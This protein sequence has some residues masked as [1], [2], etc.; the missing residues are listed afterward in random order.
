M[1]RHKTTILVLLVVVLI[2]VGLFYSYQQAQTALGQSMGTIASEISRTLNSTVTIEDIKV[3]SFN[4]LTLANVTV[5]DRKNQKIFQI[6]LLDVSFNPL[7]LL[8]KRT[9]VS[10]IRK[11]VLY[12]PDI[13]IRQN[14]DGR[15]NYEDFLP[16]GTDQDVKLR[17]TAIVKD[18]TTVVDSQQGQWQLSNLNGEIDFSNSPTVEFDVSAEHNDTKLKVKGNGVKERLS[19]R[20]YA[21]QAEIAHYRPLLPADIL[22]VNPEGR[23]HNLF[24]ALNRNSKGE[25]SYA[26]EV[27]IDRAAA[28]VRDIAITDA[29]GFFA[30]NNKE[31]FLYQG[32]VK[33]AGQ[34]VAVSGKVNIN[35]P[36]PQLKLRVASKKFDPAEF[37]PGT[38]VQGKLAFSADVAGTIDNPQVT[39]TVRM[40][41]GNITGYAVHNVVAAVHY[42]DNSLY[43]DQAGM[44]ILGGHVSA[45]G[46]IE[47][48]QPSYRLA[49]EG[50]NLEIGQIPELAGELSGRAN[51]N[52]IV[53]GADISTPSI[54]GTV[55]MS[56]GIW[57]QLS[58]SNFSAGFNKNGENI[59]FDYINFA[60][61]TGKVAVNG[62][63]T[64]QNLLLTGFGNK[65]PLKALQ[66]LF[67]EAELSGTADATARISGTLRQPL[68][69]INFDAEQ[70]QILKQ[71][72][73]IAK[74]KVTLT[75]TQA[76][77]EEIKLENRATRHVVKGSIGLTA[78]KPLDLFIYT[79]QARAEN[80]SE[81]LL[82]GE[83]ITGNVD[84]EMHITGTIANIQAQGRMKLTEG[85]FRGYLV[86]QGDGQYTRQNGIVE[87]KDF[88]IT[89]LNTNL[90]F[91]GIIQPNNQLNL[92]V[93]A[94]DIDLSRVYLDL[95][96]AVTGQADFSGKLI[97]SPQYPVFNGRFT[98]KEIAANGQH[99]TDISGQVGIT[100]KQIDIS[101]FE[102]TQQQGKYSFAGGMH[103]ETHELDGRFEVKNGELACLLGLLN[104]PM[105]QIEGKLNGE[106]IIN[107]K[108][109]K[110]NVWVNGR[111]LAGKI[112]NFPL[113]KIDFDI[114][115][116]NDVMTVNNFHAQQG[117]G[118]VIMK[119][120]A[121]LNGSLDV[122]IGAKDIDAGLL[123]AWLDSTVG[124]NGKLNMV[125]QVSGTA[126]APHAAVS[127]Q[128]NKGQVANADFDDLYGMF[129]IQNKA[130][131]VNQFFIAKGDYRAS[132]YGLIPLNALNPK[133]RQQASA[134]DQMDLKIKLDHADLSILPF[135]TK[136]VAWAAGPTQ[137][138]LTVGGTLMQP[139]LYGRLEVNNGTVKF[140][141]INSP[142]Q[143]VGVDIQFEGDKINVQAFKGQIGAGSYNLAGSAALNGLSVEDYNLS[144]SMDKLGIDSKYFK[145]PLSGQLQFTG[146]TDKPLL[147]GQV[148][149]EKNTIIIPTMPQLQKS[150]LDVALDLH[151]HIGNR[152]RVYNPLLYDLW[153]EPGQVSFAGSTQEPDV[154]GTI[155]A[156]RG[157][158]S[159]LRTQFKIQA[160]S[161]AFTQ[162]NSFEPVISLQAQTRLVSTLVNLDVKGPLSQM[163]VRLSSEPAMS[164]QAILSL[165]TLRSRY[166]DKQKNS[167]QV[168]ELGRDDVL[169]LL[170][171][172]LQVRFISEFEETTRDLL[173]LDAFRFVRTIT[174][175]DDDSVN[176]SYSDR[177]GYSLELSKYV[178][179]RMMLTYTAGI[180]HED[181]S[182]SFQ[183]DL[184]RRIGFT[185]SIDN[186]SR[187]RL[188]IEMR[189]SF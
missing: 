158:V 22:V 52:V 179:D 37:I 159:Y 31:L 100:G 137:G 187:R 112:K 35:G 173:G 84:N 127:M 88:S 113:E 53:K 34:P 70:G 181:S 130:I 132:A 93:S 29:S 79:Y 111:L 119:G 120:V 149:F 129:I 51:V 140:S 143:K 152:V 148:Y 18:G 167:G 146:N 20:I 118:E 57:R 92:D 42:K 54:F 61:G 156:A 56:S 26:G 75:A 3:S 168:P 177:E 104:V 14:S 103:L 125:A 162:Y 133:G 102:F 163:E 66:P 97:G 13:F 161:A 63:I 16:K 189:F 128:I 165:L 186:K 135:L 145:G 101:G 15:W 106:I 164:R 178:N 30:F 32:Q 39:G 82:P 2:A 7:E 73:Q 105:E 71:P 107:G 45:R 50:N 176:R 65:I 91:S 171:V 182:V 77:V 43:V 166:F 134:A 85:S 24:V 96:Y 6:P 46:Q 12:K 131:S 116:V 67:P 33:L 1:M 157:S 185:G 76:I 59:N 19:L 87:L 8:L 23:I 183:Y 78:E 21:D 47:V 117:D 95:P 38:A 68:A 139:S 155:R 122:E 188:G 72:Y 83:K 138:E 28:T 121:D 99:L 184:T 55:T 62:K 4:T 49:I 109:P 151:F 27:T 58:F 60:I 110:P 69:I 124:I 115:L 175:D 160:G 80:I 170:D 147:S 90:R 142:I 17:A 86:A 11:F 40:V 89:S 174:G 36:V 114:A 64:G 108:L 126:T 123:T 144:L 94:Q 169:S 98:A 153:L 81:L 180:N 41:K 25:L 150:N 44:D 10:A 5:Y 48:N 9:P 141:S 154:T 136:E 74:G 172:G